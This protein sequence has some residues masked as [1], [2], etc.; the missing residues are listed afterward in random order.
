MKFREYVEENKLT[1]LHFSHKLGISKNHAYNLF[2]GLATP[3]LELAW[4]IYLLTQGAVGFL[5]WLP[6][7]DIKRTCCVKKRN[8]KNK[9]R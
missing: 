9:D 6:E 8:N 4:E 5:D 7:E 3:A 2:H 1:Q